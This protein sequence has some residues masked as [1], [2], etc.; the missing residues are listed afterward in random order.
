[1]SDC[2]HVIGTAT[3]DYHESIIHAGR[4]AKGQTNFQRFNFC[5]YCGEDVA[6]EASEMEKMV[7]EHWEEFWKWYGD[8]H[9]ESEMKRAR[10]KSP[11]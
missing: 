10:A 2:N 4:E 5:P 8:L 1:M 7:A 11:Y 3:V 6:P 9:G